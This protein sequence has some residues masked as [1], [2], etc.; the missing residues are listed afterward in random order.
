MKKAKSGQPE[1]AQKRIELGRLFYNNK[2]VL[3]L[4]IFLSV[5]L[6]FAIY[7][8]Q[9]PNSNW[10]INGIPVSVN[11]ENSIAQDL[12]LEIVGEVPITVDVTVN[13]KRYKIVNLDESNFRAQVSL[14]SVTRAGEYTLPIQVIRNESDPEYS[15]VSWTPSEVTLKF[16]KIV[17]KQ[18]PVEVQAPGLTAGDGYLMETPYADVD[19]ITIKGPQNDINQIDRVVVEIPT[20]RELTESLST[21]GTAAF[22]NRDGEP[23]ESSDLECE[24]DTVSITIPIYRTRLLPLKVEFVNIPKGFPIDQLKYTLSRSSVLVASPSETIENMDSITIGP[25]DFRSIDIG[26]EIRLDVVLNAGF[27]N[28]ENVSEVTV[29]FPSYGLSSRTMELQNFVLEN[30]PAGYDVQVLS[31]RLSDVRIVGDSSLLASLTTEDLVGTIDLSQYSI[32]KGQYNVNVKIY[33]QGRI[34]A[35][36]VGEYTVDIDAAVRDPAS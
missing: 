24:N 29:T 19:Y 1:Q 13:G 12:G 25:I 10:L 14:S 16:D 17:S 27:R 7:L 15:I 36:A 32:S 21:T 8:D 23:V 11:Y 30:L 5:I 31:G 35:W 22:L 9:K 6:W 4:S 3:I 2:F 28:V 18:F 20:V 26:S 33:V 34:L